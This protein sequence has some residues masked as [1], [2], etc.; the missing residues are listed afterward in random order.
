MIRICTIHKSAYCRCSYDLEIVEILNYKF[1]L[2]TSNHVFLQFDTKVQIIMLVWE[3][4]FFL[5]LIIMGI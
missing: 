1:V 5:E 3:Y 2:L 4:L